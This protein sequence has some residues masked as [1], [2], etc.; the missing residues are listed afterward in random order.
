MQSLIQFRSVRA[1][2]KGAVGHP[3]H[4]EVQTAVYRLYK[5]SLVIISG[6]LIGHET[7]Q[8]ITAKSPIPGLN[9]FSPTNEI[10]FRA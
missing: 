9:K 3:I 1:L 6:I 7:L 4:R 10:S 5:H 2:V 8:I